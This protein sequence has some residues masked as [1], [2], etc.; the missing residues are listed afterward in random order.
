MFEIQEGLSGSIE[1]LQTK[2]FETGF[3]STHVDWFIVVLDK[4]L[5]SVC[6]CRGDGWMEN[7]SGL[8]RLTL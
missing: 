7:G 4:D 2:P 8:C 1:T 5:D 3:S 6:S